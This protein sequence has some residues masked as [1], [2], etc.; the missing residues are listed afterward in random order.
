M[1]ELCLLFAKDLQSDCRSVHLTQ[2]KGYPGPELKACLSAEPQH[3]AV[4]H[5]CLEPVEVPLLFR[6]AKQP[7]LA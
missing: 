1:L 6:G 7:L 3:P 4:R 5:T 2:S